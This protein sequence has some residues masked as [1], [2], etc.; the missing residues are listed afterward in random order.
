M[1][2]KTNIKQ[3]LTYIDIARA[4]GILFVVLGHI[5][6]FYRDSQGIEYSQILIFI[7]AFHMPLFFILS[8]ILFSEKT[9]RNLSFFDFLI[10]KVKGLVVPYLFLDITAGLYGVVVSSEIKISS[11]VEVVKNTL[12]IHCNV[13][14][15]WF[16]SA[17]FIGEIFLYFFLKYYRSMYRYFVWIPFLIIPR[18]YPFSTHWINVFVRG[19]IAFTFMLVGYYLKDYYKNDV[20]KRWDVIVLSVVLTYIIAMLNGQIDFWGSRVGNPILCLIGGLIG[21]Y[22]VIG[23]SKNIKSKL[24]VFIG[25]NTM[26]MMGTH[27][28]VFGIVWN[29]CSITFFNI[30][31]LLTANLYGEI[32]I[33]ILTIAANLPIMYLYNRYLPVLILKLK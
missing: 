4:I 1:G 12:T 21:A 3:R 20:N 26:T 8:G 13:S 10:K 24:L 23:L 28:I 2:G 9:F 14:A 16:I 19:M 15:N 27:M 32:L 6:Q 33:F 22:W 5:N 31:P 11:I 30:M 29:L 17:L 7:Y 18:Y 25:Q